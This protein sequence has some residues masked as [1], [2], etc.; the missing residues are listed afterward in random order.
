MVQCLIDRRNAPEIEVGLSVEQLTYE[1]NMD[2]FLAFHL[3]LFIHF[4]ISFHSRTVAVG[5][6]DYPDVSFNYGNMCIS[7]TRYPLGIQTIPICTVMLTL[8][9]VRTPSFFFVALPLSLPL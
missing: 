5:S 9:S 7:V 2:Y 4:V 8:R 1:M 6:A 3:V